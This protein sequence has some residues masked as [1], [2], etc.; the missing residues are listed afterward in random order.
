MRR[1]WFL[2]LCVLTFQEWALVGAVSE[3]SGGLLS[4]FRL[5]DIQNICVCFGKYL[6]ARPARSLLT[7][8]LP[9]AAEHL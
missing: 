1:F 4:I 2:P 9:S 7:F 8:L 3:N 6:A 5:K